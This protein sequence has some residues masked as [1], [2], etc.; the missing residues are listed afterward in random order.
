MTEQISDLAVTLNRNIDSQGPSKM[1]ALDR[2]DSCGGRA[3]SVFHFEVGFLHL[4]GR[5]TRLNLQKLL[6]SDPVS[7]WIAPEELWSVAGV[8]VPAQDHRASGDGLTDR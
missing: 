1:T 6:A 4:C 3:A 7:Y 5:H 8:K 2:C